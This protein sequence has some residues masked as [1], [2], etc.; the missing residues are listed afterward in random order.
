M[1]DYAKRLDE[2]EHPY[3]SPVGIKTGDLFGGYGEL[4]SI[5]RALLKENE[6]MLEGMRGIQATVPTRLRWTHQELAHWVGEVDD[7]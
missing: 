1:S 6:Q 5:A 7:E 3:R 4:L 2:L